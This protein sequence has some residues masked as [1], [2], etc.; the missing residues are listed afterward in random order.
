[1]FSKFRGAL[2]VVFLLTQG[3]C[4][5]KTG[6]KAPELA[7]PSFNGRGY[8][9]VGQIPQH[10]EK[11]ASDELN[12][13][14]ITDFVQCLQKA[15]TTFVQLTRGKHQDSYAPEEIRRFLQTFF[16]RERPITDNLMREFMVIKQVL[17]GGEL[18]VVTRTEIADLIAFLEDVRR[19]AI[20]IRPFVKFLNPRLI[21]NQEPNDIGR[22]LSEANETLRQSIRVIS[23]RLQGGQ[24][25]YSFSNLATLMTEFRLFVRWEEHFKNHQP[26]A[27]WVELFKTFK[28]ATLT[29]T[30]PDGLRTTE[31]APFLQTLSRW[32]LAYIQYRVGV[33]DRPM[34]QGVGLQ[35]TIHL[36]QELFELVGDAIHRQPNK[37]L[38]VSLVNA[39]IASAQGLDWLPKKIRPES[40]ERFT[41]ALIDRIFADDKAVPGRNQAD[42]ITLPVL[43]LMQYEFYRWAQIQMRLDQRENVERRERP[44]SPVPSL[45]TFFLPPP[46]V[47]AKLRNVR[48][49]DWEHFQKVKTK[50]RPIFNE[51]KDRVTLAN[52]ADFGRLRLSH[53]FHQLSAMNLL[54]SAVGMLY[55]GYADLSGRQWDWDSGLKSSQLQAFY[56][57]VRDLAVDLALADPR[58][59]NTGNRA[60]IE[61]NLFTHSADGVAF[62]VSKSRLTFVEAMEL[63]A[64]IY[65][66]GR[67]ATDIYNKL[68]GI[69]KLRPDLPPQPICILGPADQN[70]EATLDR[71]CVKQKL[72]D[73]IKE[74]AG[75]LPGLKQYLHSA[76]ASEREM[77]VKNLLDAAFSPKHSQI[78]WVER[79]EL[80]IIAVV[81]HYLEAVVI[82]FDANR[83]GVLSGEELR[84][85]A[86]LFS[87]FIQRYAKDH[88]QKD[89]SPRQ[90]EGVF[91]YILAYKAFPTDWNFIRVTYLSYDWKWEFNFGWGLKLPVE[92]NQNISLSRSEL[93]SVFRVIVAKLFETVTVAEQIRML[94]QEAT[95]APCQSIEEYANGGCL[96]P[97]QQN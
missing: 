32:Y 66:G 4:G 29:S 37:V 9:C 74:Y 27:A 1:M 51:N 93:S 88:K 81:L 24:R 44:P 92:F 53:D 21:V 73:L 38:E 72:P 84:S 49:A 20:R 82:R 87:G 15:F 56:D 13:G 31:W 19:E 96:M 11:F 30:Y 8:S 85:A 12:D 80:S 69:N 75:N 36:G 60:F 3:S 62:D 10:L 17:V 39:L 22:H 54:R 68:A 45:Q 94:N 6:E 43:T 71:E 33:K 5:L 23:L 67:T 65:S 40:V 91:L 89:L 26:V 16:L 79:N 46:D 61:G 14:Q 64:Y 34:L 57:D 42:G 50:I 76:P 52:E 18:T 41:R 95:P 90:A 86:P 47:R 25:D 28:R 7:P 78:P 35:N 48:D 83:N 58:V 55:R 77:L 2:A 59:S 97:G 70:G 63:L